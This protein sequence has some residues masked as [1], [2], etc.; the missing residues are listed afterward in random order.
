MHFEGMPCST[1]S[2][3]SMGN[4]VAK[5]SLMT[6]LLFYTGCSSEAQT[7]GAQ[8]NLPLGHRAL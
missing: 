3:E 8:W 6:N 1:S 4:V 7:I 2:P 5:G